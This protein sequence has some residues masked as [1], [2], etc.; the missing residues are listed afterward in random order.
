MSKNSNQQ[1][2]SAFK[3]WKD[4]LDRKRKVNGKHKPKAKK[5]RPGYHPALDYNEGEE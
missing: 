2:L 1:N 3:D 4:A 5:I